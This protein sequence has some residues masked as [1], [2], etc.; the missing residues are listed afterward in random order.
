MASTTVSPA[1]LFGPGAI[2]ATPT[3]VFTAPA[4]TT[5]TINRIVVTN[6]GTGAVGLSIWLSRGG[7]TP[8]GGNLILGPLQSIAAGPSEPYIVNC[9]ASCVLRAGD[10]IYMEASTANTL[11]TF[12]SGWQQ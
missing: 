4:N 10:S 11:N 6:T 12:G 9:L 8:S 5:I 2:P 1:P 3:V 7:A